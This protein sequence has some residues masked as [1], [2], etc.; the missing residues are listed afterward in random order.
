MLAPRP[1]I[2]FVVAVRSRRILQQAKQTLAVGFVVESSVARRDDL[3]E[4]RCVDDS[5]KHVA[6]LRHDR[7]RNHATARNETLR[8]GNRRGP[9][10]GPSQEHGYV[11]RKFVRVACSQVGRA[12]ARVRETTSTRSRVFYIHPRED[13]PFRQ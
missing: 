2:D 10:L 9:C 6:Q 5:M 13:V 11:R 4:I 12:R 1:G 8:P 3:G 7:R